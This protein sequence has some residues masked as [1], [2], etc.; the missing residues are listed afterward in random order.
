[1][2]LY[3][4][5][6]AGGGGVLKANQYFPRE[7]ATKRSVEVQT[8]TVKNITTKESCI[9]IAIPQKP[10]SAICMYSVEDISAI[11]ESCGG[12]LLTTVFI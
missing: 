12:Q 3:T 1:M 6:Y 11:L 9:E 5:L 4:G 7:R 8:E 2:L 10:I